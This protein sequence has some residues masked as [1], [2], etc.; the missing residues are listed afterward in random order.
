M[1][2][3][4][5]IW[6]FLSDPRLLRR[7]VL[8][9]AGF[10][11]ASAFFVG[12]IYAWEFTSTPQFCGTTCHTMPAEYSAYQR[13]PHA[14]VDCVNCHIP[15]G[16]NSAVAQKLSDVRHVV[17]ITLNRYETPIVVRSLRPAREVCERCHW[18]EKA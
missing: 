7:A 15:K 4:K 5:R 8:V 1:G 16:V 13:S 6:A 9:L 2:L 3:L 10:V 18:P 11:L 14:R 17:D 12:A